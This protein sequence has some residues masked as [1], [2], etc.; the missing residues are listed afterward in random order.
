MKIELIKKFKVI[1]NKLHKFLLNPLSILLI[2]Y[3]TIWLMR[4]N[5]TFPLIEI[6]IHL[7]FLII[8]ISFYTH[9]LASNDFIRDLIILGSIKDFKSR[10]KYYF[11]YY[12]FHR[13]NAREKNSNYWIL[14]CII[15]WCYFGYMYSL[16]YS[17][18]ITEKRLIEEYGNG[19][20]GFSTFTLPIAL[21]FLFNLY[22]KTL[23]EFFYLKNIYKTDNF[24]PIQKI[25]KSH[26]HFSGGE[27]EDDS[28]FEERIIDEYSLSGR[29]YLK[30]YISD[31]SIHPFE[32]PLFWIAVF[33]I[34]ITKL[35]TIISSLTKHIITSIYFIPLILVVIA[36]ISGVV[37][38]KENR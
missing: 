14:L 20:I 33:F 3:F 36:I 38:R 4:D 16:I 27:Y 17:Q 2:V 10:E 23:H 24:L 6:Y 18:Q 21:T 5:Y 26:Y 9:H 12:E 7:S 1:N 32:R 30:F 31:F 29:N 35:T 37:E 28:S 19:S 34:L 13:T 8:C 22:H 25:Y 11:G 15:L